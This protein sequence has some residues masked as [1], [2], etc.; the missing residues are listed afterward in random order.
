MFRTVM[1]NREPGPRPAPWLPSNNSFIASVLGT[2]SNIVSCQ[3]T[4]SL[5]DLSSKDHTPTYREL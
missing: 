4:V 1:D 5:S 3:S 2:Y